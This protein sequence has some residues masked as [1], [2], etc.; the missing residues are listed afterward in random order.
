MSLLAFH[1]LLSLLSWKTYDHLRR[2]GTSHSGLGSPTTIIYQKCLK[3]PGQPGLHRETLSRK[4]NQKT[5]QPT[6]QPTNQT[7]KQ[8]NKK[9]RQWW[10][11]PL[12]PVLRKQRQMD[13]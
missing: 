7:N 4:E 10:R 5:N 6:N 8:T 12:I 9:A 3:V 2:D 13:F 11:T 1:S